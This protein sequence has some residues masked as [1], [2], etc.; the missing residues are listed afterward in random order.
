MQSEIAMVDMQSELQFRLDEYQVKVLK[1]VKR[2][3]TNCYI[4]TLSGEEPPYE[5]LSNPCLEVCNEKMALNFAGHDRACPAC[6]TVAHEW[7]NCPTRPRRSQRDT[8]CAD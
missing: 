6:F 2:A 3:G 8:H 1:I 4:V 5:L 7:K